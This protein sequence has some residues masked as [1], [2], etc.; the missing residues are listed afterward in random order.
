MAVDSYQKTYLIALIADDIV[1]E[2]SG[3][4]LSIHNINHLSNQ[5]V[6]GPEILLLLLLKALTISPSSTVS[7]MCRC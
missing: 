5:I 4:I 7:C 6:I 1:D 3:K 2:E